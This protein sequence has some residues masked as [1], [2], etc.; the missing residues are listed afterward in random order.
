MITKLKKAF[1]E[2]GITFNQLAG[3]RNMTKANR[4][5]E[6][7]VVH[8]TAG[9][10]STKN[11]ARNTINWFNNPQAKGSADFVVDDD[12]ILMYSPDLDTY[13]TYHCGGSK[14][15]N[16][17]G[18]FYNIATNR[19]SIGIEICSST[20]T[21]KLAPPNSDLVYFSDAVLDNA[22]RLIK[23]LMKVYNVPL[24]KVIRHYDCT[25]KLCPGV[26]GW[27]ADS[28]SEEEWEKFKTRFNPKAAISS[29]KKTAPSPKSYVVR[30][31]KE[32][33]VRAEPK[34]HSKLVKTVDKGAYT[35]VETRGEWGLL[36]SK[37]GWL[38]LKYTK[39]L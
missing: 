23:A 31:L 29:K 37:L 16:L 32:C 15:N 26:K 22:E 6:Y 8:Y 20:K 38:N 7:I 35:V 13:F 28:G 21:L 3:R 10:R 17:G 18:K 39:P 24:E 30:I 12:E 19:N 5:I 33:E 36:K 11:A 1:Q 2:F 25:G 34:L 4:K 14:Y 27:N 9:T